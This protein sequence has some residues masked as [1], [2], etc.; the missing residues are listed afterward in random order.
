[1]NDVSRERC[2]HISDFSHDDRSFLR[3]STV[4]FL[5]QVSLIPA[6][7]AVELVDAPLEAGM[8]FQSV[9]SVSFCDNFLS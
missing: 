4:E 9:V 7:V 8:A 2:Q 1:M 5:S 6:R 3:L